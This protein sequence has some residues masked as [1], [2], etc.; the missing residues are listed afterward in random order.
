MKQKSIGLEL[1]V[2]K[3][4]P[5]FRSADNPQKTD[6]SSFQHHISAN[7]LCGLVG[8][9]VLEKKKKV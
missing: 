8:P 5:H 4:I 2:Q 6:E 3:K 1:T 7:I 9:Y